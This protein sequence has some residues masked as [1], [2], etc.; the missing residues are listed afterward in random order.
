MYRFL[1]APNATAPIKT[2]LGVR[3]SLGSSASKTPHPFYNRCEV[4]DRIL[5]VLVLHFVSK[6]QATPLAM[7]DAT[8]LTVIAQKVWI[9]HIFKAGGHHVHN[10]TKAGGSSEG[11]FDPLPQ[12]STRLGWSH[13]TC[14]IKGV[15]RAVE[16]DFVQEHASYEA[17]H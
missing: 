15:A 14:E 5:S 1:A 17:H 10:I 16:L 13:E 2:R 4:S 7:E 12:P 11:R 8:K 6:G 9:P 3:V